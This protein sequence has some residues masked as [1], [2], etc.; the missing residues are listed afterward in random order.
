MKPVTI[1]RH[2]FSGELYKFV[3]YNVGSTSEIK[4]LFSK[5]IKLTAGFDGSSKLKIR[6]DEPLALGFLIKDIKDADGNLILDDAIWQ[7]SGVFPV[8]NA[9]NTV[10]SYV[11]TGVKFQGTL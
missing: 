6:A 11:M 8:V 10:E 9:F 4:Y 5:S 2:K 1:P 3:R 7:I